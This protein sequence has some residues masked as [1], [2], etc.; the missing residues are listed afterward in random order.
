MGQRRWSQHPHVD[1]TGR[2]LMTIPCRVETTVPCA[3][4][5]PLQLGADLIRLNPYWWSLKPLTGGRERLSQDLATLPRQYD[6]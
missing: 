6:Q 2:R 4:L 3:A 5:Q 1:V